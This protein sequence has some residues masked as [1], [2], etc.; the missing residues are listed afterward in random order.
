MYTTMRGEKS[1]KKNKKQTN[2]KHRKLERGGPKTN[3]ILGI[4]LEHGSNCEV[5]V[6]FCAARVISVCANQVHFGVL[7]EHR[8]DLLQPVLQA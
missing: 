6:F 5:D 4:L 8:F 3:N 2:E 1:S 7:G